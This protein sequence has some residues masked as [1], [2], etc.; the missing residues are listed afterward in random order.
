MLL[1]A[2]GLRLAGKSTRA[3]KGG[4][5]VWRGLM[6]GRI[7]LCCES[8]FDGRLQRGQGSLESPHL[9]LLS[10]HAQPSGKRHLS[11]AA[12]DQLL[13]RQPAP[14]EAQLRWP[15]Q[16]HLPRPRIQPPPSGPGRERSALGVAKLDPNPLERHDG[17]QRGAKQ[18]PHGPVAG[19]RPRRPNAEHRPAPRILL[20]VL[21]PRNLLADAGEGAWRR[22]GLTPSPQHRPPP[23]RHR[24]EHGPPQPCPGGL[25]EKTHHL[26]TR[27]RKPGRPNG[28]PGSVMH[29]AR[30]RLRAPTD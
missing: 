6:A 10:C 4:Q 29:R 14:V 18:L 21:N 5:P 26:L 30:R 17:P 20:H 11:V 19:H 23:Q 28:L 15:R 8:F 22:F 1:R 24:Q 7:H 13:C 27:F 9:H 25:R 3:P 12:D 16:A 2:P